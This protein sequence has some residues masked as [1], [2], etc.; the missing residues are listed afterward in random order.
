MWIE[1]TSY[2]GS[3]LI[4]LAFFMRAIVP[5]RLAAIGSNV[6]F[7]IYA[8]Y[9]GLIP[10]LVLDLALLPLNIWRIIE[11]RRLERQVREASQGT[12]DIAKAVPFMK[13]TEAAAG[14]TLFEKGDAANQLYY[15]EE[16]RVRLEEVG[17][18]I[19]P[20]ALLGEIALFLEDAGR[21]ATATCITDCRMLI[22]N[23]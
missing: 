2:I 14:D 23:C 12:P 22:L 4:F 11:Y 16:G 18:E 3:A 17:V 19:G 20:G 5:L 9:T 8:A 10:I 6:F 1:A 15:L 13:A 7:I 21:T